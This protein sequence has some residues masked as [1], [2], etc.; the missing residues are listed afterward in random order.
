[1]EYCFLGKKAG[2][3]RWVSREKTKAIKTSLNYIFPIDL[4]RKESKNADI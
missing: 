1:L 4:L 3:N 2:K